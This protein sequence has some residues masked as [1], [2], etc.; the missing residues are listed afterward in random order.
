MIY[1]S[2]ELSEPIIQGDIFV[3]IP[4]VEISLSRLILVDES[5]QPRETT[6]RDTIEDAGSGE[7]VTAILP[8]KPVKAIVITQ[9]CDAVRGESLVLSQIDR[10]VDLIGS[11]PPDRG[12][13]S[14]WAKLITKQSREHLRYFYL[15]VDESAG[16]S[17]RMACDFRVL[18]RTPRVDLEQML[19][20][21]RCRL[22]AEAR[23]HFRETLAQYFRR[24]PYN[25]WY[26]LTPDEFEAY[27]EASPEPVK[28]Y[29]WQSK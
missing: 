3:G 29:P 28:P 16:F 13:H 20:L 1:E 9:N 24:Y 22:N 26:P 17:E 25:E 23:E 15:P 2:A 18:L 27:A 11:T 21:R 5:D 8:I 10:Y 4:R 14:K 12:K 7:G 19:D 6:W